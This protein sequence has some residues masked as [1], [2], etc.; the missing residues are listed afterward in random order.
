[1]SASTWAD[2]QESPAP[3]WAVVEVMGHRFHAG[4]ISEQIIAGSGFLKVEA[5]SVSAEDP[6]VEQWTTVLYQPSALFSIRPAT[7]EQVRRE[8]PKFYPARP[9][10][11]ALTPGRY[12]LDDDLEDQHP[13]GCS[14][15]DCEPF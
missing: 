9:S 8:A 4:K 7:E 1:M 15:E 3:M 5:L 14:C 2:E 10:A 6:T 13:D 11:P 12:P